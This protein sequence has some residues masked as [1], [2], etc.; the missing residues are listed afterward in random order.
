MALPRSLTQIFS[1]AKLVVG[2]GWRCYFAPF[3]RALAATTAQTIF[4]PTILDLTTGPFDSN[5]PWNFE[6]GGAAA[7]NTSFTD[8]GWIK[9][10]KMTSESK[11]GQ[12]RSGYR[13]AIRVQYRGQVGESIEFK[14]REYGRQQYKMAAG[15]NV[16]NL[17]GASGLS[18]GTSGPLSASGAPNIAVS[19]YSAGSPPYGIGGKGVA[20]TLT[21]ASAPAGA[22]I[23]VNSYIVC[24]IDYNTASFGLVGDTGVPVFQNAVTDIDYIRKNSDY[25]ALVTA[26]NGNVLT[27]QYPFV[28]GGSG[29]PAPYGPASISPQSKVE[30][31][32]GWTS[33]EGGTFIAEWTALFLN[34]TIDGA[35]L[36]AYYPHL[37]IGQPRDVAASWAIENIGTTDLGG[38]ELDAQYNAL[39]FDDPLDGE[40]IVS[41]RMYYPRF[42][43]PPVVGA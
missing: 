1:P 8:G 31:I 5:N 26:I 28:G 13:G 4:G 14:F 9:D 10:F 25:V 17:L 27:L 15:T 35:Q 19:S 30:V 7:P 41:Y 12:V 23:G 42:Q 11:I 38:F 3:N 43:E 39:A 21:L 29:N 18:G 34:N 36:G 22:Q 40:T 37:S 16:I 33:R 6:S 2:A 32:K 24:D 20:A